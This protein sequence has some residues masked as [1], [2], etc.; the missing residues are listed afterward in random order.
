MTT[1]Y[2]CDICG[3]ETKHHGNAVLDVGQ[4]GN[5]MFDVCDDCLRK[6]NLKDV[7]SSLWSK[8]EVRIIKSATFYITPNFLLKPESSIREVK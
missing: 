1:K 4:S 3:N 5:P 6:K 8:T 7:V 2:Y